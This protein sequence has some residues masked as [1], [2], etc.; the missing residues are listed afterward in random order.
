MSALLPA[1]IRGFAFGDPTGEIAG[2]AAI[3][4]GGSCSDSSGGEL[5]L[6]GSGPGEPWRLQ[7]DGLDLT[8]APA[9]ESVELELA[10]AG[11]A[12]AY[13]LARVTGHLVRDG[14]ELAVDC[15]GQ[16]SHRWGAPDGRRFQALRVV[17]AC[18]AADT[19]LVV[20][21]ARPR[22]AR[23]HESD[24]MA[25]VLV[26]GG[27]PVDIFEPRLSSTYTTDGVPRRVGLEL[28]IGDEDDE[29]AENY[30]RRAAAAAIGPWLPCG[31]GGRLE[32][33]HWRMRGQE[34]VGVYE[35]VQAP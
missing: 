26:E 14:E 16:R 27:V 12:L 17:S 1:D 34:G 33:L 2:T 18:F 32:L 35:L 24:L 13:Q 3:W 7:G 5:R 11:L 23:G 10:E 21:A 15:A 9:G 20:L 6:D 19:G 28:W 22:K 30:T 4:E 31:E 29:E 25:G 8:F